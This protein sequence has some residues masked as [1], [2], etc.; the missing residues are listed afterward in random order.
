MAG[1]G[2]GFNI[3]PTTGLPVN[4]TDFKGLL[5]DPMFSHFIDL[6]SP[7]ISPLSEATIGPISAN[8]P[9]FSISPFATGTP[10]S[11]NPP[12]SGLPQTNFGQ[13]SGGDDPTT[14]PPPSAVNVSG[15]TDSPVNEGAGNAPS[16]P[17]PGTGAGGGPGTA[18]GDASGAGVGSGG[19]GAYRRG[20]WIRDTR[21][22]GGDNERRRLQADE[23][24]VRRSSA[25]KYRT[26]L[27]A[28]N[29]DRPAE[30]KRLASKLR[31]RFAA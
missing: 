3:N 23:F 16:G 30:V 7:A 20:G 5:S 14:A 1:F 22:G 8:Q 15:I 31:A 6:N 24:V 2:T 27:E 19:E 11:A 17:G 9:G 12:G 4:S 10:F 21:P 25:T 18:S 13:R 26:L 29:G 28:I